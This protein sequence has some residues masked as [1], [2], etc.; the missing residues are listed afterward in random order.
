[1]RKALI[2]GNNAYEHCSQL[3]SCINDAEEI[4]ALLRRHE[5][6]TSNFDVHLMRNVN[7]E[8]MLS[9]IEQLFSGECDSALLYYSGHG[10]RE[11][12]IQG[13]VPIDYRGHAQAVTLDSIVNCAAG[14]RTK[15][16]VIILD[17][18]HAGGIGESPVRANQ[19]S[20]LSSGLTI[21]AACRPDE[22]AIED[23]SLGH[24]IFTQ[25]LIDGLKG[26]AADLNG[27]ITAGSLY[28]YIDKS[29][30]PWDQRPVFKTN[31]DR[32]CSLR[33]VTPPISAALLRKLPEYFPDECG[34]H[35][36]DPSYEFTNSPDYHQELKEPYADEAHVEIL[37]GLQK[38]ERVGLVVPRHEQHMYF[39]AMNS[40]GCMLTPLGRYYRQLVLSDRI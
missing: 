2:I 10:L 8:D 25:L 13:L 17:S 12:C 1:M 36:L 16:K 14:C 21:L 28:T 3:S 34:I 37:K 6:Y 30:G 9:S 7:H 11:N 39:A 33:K 32:F 38:M 18:C 15:N 5:D 19:G 29:L 31:V 35:D 22:Y 26:A 20:I 24:G 23:A 4:G 40:T 27:E